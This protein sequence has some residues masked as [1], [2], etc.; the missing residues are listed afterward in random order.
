MSIA[1]E[2]VTETFEYDGSQQVTVYV[3]PDPPEA[4]VFAGDG[5]VTLLNLR[6]RASQTRENRRDRDEH[7]CV[8]GSAT[9]ALDRYACDAQRSKHRY[10][11]LVRARRGSG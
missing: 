3:P 8:N 1:R 10:S 11:R 4:I 9:P 5:Q 2:F 6:I 7:S